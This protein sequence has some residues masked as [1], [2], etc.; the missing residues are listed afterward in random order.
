MV[1]MKVKLRIPSPAPLNGSGVLPGALG[2]VGALDKALQVLSSRHGADS[3]PGPKSKISAKE[4]T[5]A[6]ATVPA[7]GARAGGTT[8]SLKEHDDCASVADSL[9]SL[10]KPVVL[11]RNSEC[12]VACRLLLGLKK[13]KTKKSG[14]KVSAPVRRLPA[15][16]DPSVRAALVQV[17]ELFPQIDAQ[18]CGATGRVKS[19]PA[20]PAAMGRDKRAGPRVRAL[21][22][23]LI[24][25]LMNQVI[26]AEP[27]L[28][29]EVCMEVPDCPGR[30]RRLD[31]ATVQKNREAKILTRLAKGGRLNHVWPLIPEGF[32]F[33][34]RLYNI[35]FL[36][37]PSRPDKDATE[38]AGGLSRHS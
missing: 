4:A 16:S 1:A 11:G 12:Q 24:T 18:R 14:K 7:P 17:S 29:A 25:A 3:D 31:Q 36:R 28:W 9:L 35:E 26:A 33:D 23:K 30:S 2:T 32:P 10:Q 15:L 21:S 34:F 22:Q 37:S 6:A 38:P 13:K 19:D 20:T 27:Q 5:A 8:I